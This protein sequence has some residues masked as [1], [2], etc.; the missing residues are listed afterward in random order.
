[1]KLPL[2]LAL[3]AAAFMAAAP[4]GAI[5]PATQ[6]TGL[7]ASEK[8]LVEG[9]REAVVRTGMS[10][11]HFDGHFRVERV[12]DRPGDRRVVWR[13]TVGGHEALVTDS[14]GFYTEGGRRFDTHSVAGVLGTTGDL[15]NV[16]AR[17]RAERIMRRCLGRFTNPQVEYRAHG[18]GGAAA[19]LLTAE[20]LVTTRGSTGHEAREREEREQRERR[21]KESRQSRNSRRTDTV[22]EEDEGGDG[23]V[24]L[25][26]AVDLSDGSCTVGRGQVGPPAAP[27]T[28]Q[29]PR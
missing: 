18:P 21:E 14:I 16:I 13:F 6:Q 20:R 23:V 3:S 2:L 29:S 5:P 24:V 1:M 7:T 19:L 9:S 25:F 27:G 4:S 22:D 28:R 11:E 15:T 26:G 17:G 10:A 8:S 12:Y